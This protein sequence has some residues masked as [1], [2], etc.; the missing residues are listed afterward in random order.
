MED[1]KQA[2]DSQDLGPLGVIGHVDEVNGAGSLE[3]PD[4]VPTRH[5]LIQLVKY[6][7][8][9]ALEIIYWWIVYGTT[10]STEIR[11]GPFAERRIGKI[12]KLLGEDEVAKAIKEAHDKFWGDDHETRRI[13]EEGT[14]EEVRALQDE[15]RRKLDEDL[16]ARDD[17][18]ARQHIASCDDQA[19]SKGDD[20][21]WLF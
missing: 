7:A 18:E 19:R 11:V 17:G 21:D 2:D 4:F 13:V 3:V 8:T 9:E 12:A 20:E 16:K 14:P 1:R 15:V 5:E 10:G 6:W